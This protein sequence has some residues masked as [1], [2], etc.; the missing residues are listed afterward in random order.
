MN[1]KEGM[2]KKLLLAAAILVAHTGALNATS[3]PINLGLTRVTPF[4]GTSFNQLN[5]IA[6]NGQLLSL[7]F[8]FTHNFVRLIPLTGEDFDIALSLDTNANGLPG[9]ASGRGF[10]FDQAGNP[11]QPPER[12][13]S[14]AS[15]T[16]AIFLGLF[17]LLDGAPANASFYGLHMDI[18]LPNNP[19]FEIIGEHLQLLG[20]HIQGVVQGQFGIGPHVADNGSTLALFAFALLALRAL[21]KLQMRS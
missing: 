12:L 9:F 16:G 15:D 6:L 3:I 2:T 10:I 20:G 7:N 17:P 14:A 11:L 8:V 19:G 5:G 13:G 21:S 4:F 18:T 1:I